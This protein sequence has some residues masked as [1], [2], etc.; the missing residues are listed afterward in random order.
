MFPASKVFKRT[1]KQLE[2][3]SVERDMCRKAESIIT[4]SV[5]F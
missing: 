3:R 1:S 4:D 2:I 5:I